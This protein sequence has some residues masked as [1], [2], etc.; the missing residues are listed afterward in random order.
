MR[1]TSP[2][3]TVRL[4]CLTWRAVTNP[5]KQAKP[6]NLKGFSLLSHRLTPRG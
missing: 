5:V 1:E 2:E 6:S 3:T 4:A